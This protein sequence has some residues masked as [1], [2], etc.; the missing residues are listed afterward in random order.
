MAEI[1]NNQLRCIPCPVNLIGF[2]L[3]FPHWWSPDF[4]SI[5][6][7]K[8]PGF[9]PWG[10]M[11]GIFTYISH[12]N[13]P[14][15][16]KYTIH[17]SSWNSIKQPGFNGK[18]RIQKSV[19]V[20]I[21]LRL[22]MALPVAALLLHYLWPSSNQVLAPKG[23]GVWKCKGCDQKSSKALDIYCIC[24]FGIYSWS[25]KSERQILWMNERIT[26]ICSWGKHLMVLF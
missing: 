4:W 11:Y 23:S 17:G 7:I 3:P 16:S 1:P 5:N 21:F 25:L 12:K 18:H 8:Q 9:N 20:G 6:S 10:S 13:Q 26:W 2:Q 19:F 22:R 14:N 24:F 15:V